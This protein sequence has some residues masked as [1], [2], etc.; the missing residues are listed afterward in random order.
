MHF[1]SRCLIRSASKYTSLPPMIANTGIVTLLS[2]S[3]VNVGIGVIKREPI[4]LRGAPV[5]PKSQDEC[6]TLTRRNTDLLMRSRPV[7]EHRPVTIVNELATRLGPEHFRHGVPSPGYR[8]TSRNTHGASG[9]TFQWA[10]ALCPCRPP[11]GNFYAS[12]RTA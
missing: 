12:G 4:D 10:R 3:S 11:N 8:S 7:G 2:C 1:S 9:E 6:F 5:W